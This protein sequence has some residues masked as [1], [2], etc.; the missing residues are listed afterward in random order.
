MPAPLEQIDMEAVRQ[1]FD[2]YWRRETPEVPL[3]AITCPRDEQTSRDFDVPPTVD[4][5]WTNIE[6]QC[7]RAL[8]QARNTYYLG[9]A[10]PMAMPNIGPDS[11]TAYLGGR[12]EFV[13][14]GTTWIRPFV[15]D[16]DE[17]EPTLDPENHWWRHMGKLIDA[18]CKAAPGNFMVGVPDLH[19]GGDSLSAARHPDKLALDLY[20]KPESVRRVMRRLT[21]IYKDVL[22]DYNARIGRVQKGSTTWLRAYSRG[23]FTALQNDFSGLVSPDMFAEFFL[24]EIRELAAELDN[25]IYHLDGP[26]ALGN[27]PLL[28]QV[29]ELDGIQWV[30]GAGAPPMSEWAHVCRQIL[31]GGKC[32]FIGCGAEHLD[33]LLSALP[34]EG[35]YIGTGCSTE[36]DGRALERHVA[37]KFGRA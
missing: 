24:D 17:F 11:F 27:L 28:L 2:I 21:D 19:G 18:M 26:S 12:L 30:P 35:L 20:D 9:A 10:F 32:C 31:E 1:R 37:Q 23:T 4:E 6:Y 34:H 25:S 29:E 3:V 22:S 13:D 36:K 8:W 7:R 33:G 14:D 15:D 5:R 16:L